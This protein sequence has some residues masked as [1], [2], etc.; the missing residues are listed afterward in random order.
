MHCE[1]CGIAFPAFKMEPAPGFGQ[2][3]AVMNGKPYPK[4]GYI[5]ADCASLLEAAS[6]AKMW[7]L[8]PISL[9][10]GLDPAPFRRSER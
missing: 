2:H 4:Q 1:R 3:T 8:S 7:V 10:E 5:C 9:T 6:Y